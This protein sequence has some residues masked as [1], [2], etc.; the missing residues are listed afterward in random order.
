MTQSGLAKPAT[1]PLRNV[2][3][4]YSWLW[5]AEGPG[6]QRMYLKSCSYQYRV[7]LDKDGRR[8]FD[9]D[10]P[11]DES[12]ESARRTAPRLDTAATESCL[13]SEPSPDPSPPWT[14]LSAESPPCQSGGSRRWRRRNLRG[15][16]RENREQNGSRARGAFH[17]GAMAAR[18]LP[19]RAQTPALARGARRGGVRRGRRGGRG[20][21]ILL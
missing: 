15:G 9:P 14:D 13:P 8:A 18:R 10:T 11:I 20:P 4:G 1:V 2:P 6:P 17:R 7:W 3:W 12:L 19:V 5:A 16:G 21:A